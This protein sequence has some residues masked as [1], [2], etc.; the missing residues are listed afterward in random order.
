MLRNTVQVTLGTSWVA[1]RLSSD[2]PRHEASTPVNGTGKLCA[3]Q[4]QDWTS[5]EVVG[6]EW[7]ASE[8]LW[9][10]PREAGGPSD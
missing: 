9:E 6:P 5:G 7:G 10:G 3:G 1:L 4:R 2:R 8:E